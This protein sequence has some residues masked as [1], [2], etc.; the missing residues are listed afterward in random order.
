MSVK[1]LVVVNSSNHLVLLNLFVPVMQVI[2]SFAIPFVSLSLTLLVIVGQL[3]LKPL[4]D[5]F[6][7]FDTLL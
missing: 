6:N 1:S 3:T 5:Q 4:G 2:L 7:P